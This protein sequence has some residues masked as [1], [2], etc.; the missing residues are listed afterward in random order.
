V[1]KQY[2]TL[3]AANPELPILIRECAGVEAK[4][5]ARFGGSP[6]HKV[7]PPDEALAARH[8]FT[9]LPVNVTVVLSKT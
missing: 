4:A 1:L 8:A 5:Y 2:K 9:E 6:A 3:K 7:F